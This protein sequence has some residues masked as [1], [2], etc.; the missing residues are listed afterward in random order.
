MIE[1]LPAACRESL[2]VIAHALLA[3][4]DRGMPD[5]NALQIASWSAV[6]TNDGES[7]AVSVS[8]HAVDSLESGDITVMVTR[9]VGV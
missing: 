1:P 7:G 9:E 8:I 3:L 4:A 6:P 5:T 2:R